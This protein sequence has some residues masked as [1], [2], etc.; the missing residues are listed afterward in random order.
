[1]S[2]GPPYSDENRQGDMEFMGQEAW[3]GRKI[4]AAYMHCDALEEALKLQRSVR[5]RFDCVEETITSLPPSLGVHSS[6][7]TVGVSFYPVDYKR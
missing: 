7:G 3:S 6:P 5:S 1:M 4:K 2:S